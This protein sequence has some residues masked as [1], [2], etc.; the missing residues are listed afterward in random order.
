MRVNRTS[1]IPWT[2]VSFLCYRFSVL[3]SYLIKASGT[4]VSGANTIVINVISGSAGD[5]FLWAFC[6]LVFLFLEKGC[7]LTLGHLILCLTPFVSIRL[8]WDSSK[9]DRSDVYRTNR[10]YSVFVDVRWSVPESF[11]SHSPRYYETLIYFGR[12]SLRVSCL[13]NG[14]F[15]FA[16]NKCSN[17]FGIRP[18][19]AVFHSWMTFFVIMGLTYRIRL[20]KKKSSWNHWQVRGKIISQWKNSDVR[21]EEFPISSLKFTLVPTPIVA[22]IPHLGHGWWESCWMVQGQNKD[23]PHF[24]IPLCVTEDLQGISRGKHC[25]NIGPVCSLFF[26]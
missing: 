19:M 26:L 22:K 4:L 14:C 16:F 9:Y 12:A 23:S 3:W 24:T 8:W 7:W 21:G 17:Y 20:E 5:G 15:P 2:F 25:D 18:V 13:V 6:T 1:C 10:W 11:G